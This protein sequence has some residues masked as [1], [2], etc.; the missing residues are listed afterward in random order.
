MPRSLCSGEGNGNLRIFGGTRKLRLTVNELFV[1]SYR[2]VHSWVWP[3]RA[4]ILGW[5]P[6]RILACQKKYISAPEMV[7]RITDEVQSA[8]QTLYPDTEIR[9]TEIRDTEI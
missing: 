6:I 9:D 7:I 3:N 1:G 4:S 8:F 5:Y 2:N